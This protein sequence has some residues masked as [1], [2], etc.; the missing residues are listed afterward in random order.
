MSPPTNSYALHRNYHSSA[1]LNAQNH[2]WKDALGYSLHP[3]IGLTP[4]SAPRI[5]DIG[6]GTGI[7]M[8]DVKREYPAA[9]IDGFDISF[10]QCPPPE[11]LPDGV[12]LRELDLYEPLPTELEGIYDVVHLRLFF[13]VIR[14]DDP[15]PVLRNMLRMLKPGGWLQWSEHNYE[16]WSVQSVGGRETPAL[17]EMMKLMKQTGLGRWV[18]GLP[19]LFAQHGMVD[20]R[21]ELHPCSPHSRVYW[22]QLQFNSN[23]EYSY[24]AMDNSTS[25]AAGPRLRTLIGQAADECR[26]GAGFD[27]TLEVALGRKSAGEAY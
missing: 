23:E 1:R 24:L 10:A 19:D 9:Q 22:S 12:R 17:D 18:P 27:F 26:Q 4:D 16:S 13:V 8:M 3:C 2:L 21:K 5:A 25:E 11:W 6:T 15:G 7:W 20:V 14:N